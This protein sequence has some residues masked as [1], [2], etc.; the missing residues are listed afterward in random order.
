MRAVIRCC[1]AAFALS[2]AACASGNIASAPVASDDRTVSALSD[3]LETAAREDL[4]VEKHA[5]L[6]REI[7]T[8]K[9]AGTLDARMLEALALVSASE[10]MYLHGRLD[11]AVELLDEAARSLKPKR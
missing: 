6:L 9:D 5:H 8:L 10:E 1:A 2:L 4:F 11:I 7:H 3:S